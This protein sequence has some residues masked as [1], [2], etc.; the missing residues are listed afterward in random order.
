[1]SKFTGKGAQFLVNTAP[2]G[3]RTYVAFGQVAEIGEIGVTADEVEVTTLDA[4]DYR[5]YI[6]G[7]KDPGE[8]GLTIMFHPELAD[9]GTATN[10]I[11]GLF[12]SG[13]LKNCAIRVNSSDVALQ[14][15]Y[16][17]F[18]AFIRDLNYGAWNP[19]DPQTISPVFR[20][21]GAITLLDALPALA[22]A[23]AEAA[24]EGAPAEK[25]A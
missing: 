8:C 4:G 21:T 22:E 16:L 5:Q 25:A 24:A 14:K 23:E 3:A 17:T 6:Q 10:G 9:Q 15:A 11:I 2:S 7:F 1:M 20:I 19:D 12:A 13:A 18:D